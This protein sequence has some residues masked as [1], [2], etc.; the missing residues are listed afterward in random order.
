MKTIISITGASSKC[1]YSEHYY[2]YFYYC[3]L[4]SQYWQRNL[5]VA[6]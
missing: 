6:K 1:V 2:Y 4:Y 3:E 5:M